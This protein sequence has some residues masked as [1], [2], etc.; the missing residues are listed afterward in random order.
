MVSYHRSLG[1]RH[2]LILALNIGGC[3]QDGPFTFDKFKL[4]LGPLPNPNITNIHCLTRDFAEPIALNNLQ[5]GVIDEMMSK[6]DFGAFA[7]RTEG[8]PSF[9][10]K[11]VHGGGHFGIGGVLGSMGDAF[12]SPGGE[13]PPGPYY[14]M[15]V[16]ILTV[17]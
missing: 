16:S 2:Q 9:D 13:F 5:Q 14:L 12:N 7:R 6:K 11:N 4:S 3:V 15:G 10:V 8:E 1:A 17:W